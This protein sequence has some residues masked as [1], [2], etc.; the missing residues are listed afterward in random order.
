ME[1]REE[2]K[3]H[4]YKQLWL[5]SGSQRCRRT[6]L[7]KVQRKDVLQQFPRRKLDIIISNYCSESFTDWWCQVKKTC[8]NQALEVL[9]LWNGIPLKIKE[10]I[11]ENKRF[12]SVGTVF[13][14][15]LKVASGHLPCMHRFHSGTQNAHV[16]YLPMRFICMWVAVTYTQVLFML[17]FCHIWKQLWGKEGSTIDSRLFLDELK[18]YICV[19]VCVRAHMCSCFVA[20][21]SN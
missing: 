12:F 14:F 18:A 20:S 9:D 6:L 19:C 1:H 11:L 7:S 8:V 10:A 17:E 2:R 5:I 15:P 16:S 4:S 13:F 21:S 3:T